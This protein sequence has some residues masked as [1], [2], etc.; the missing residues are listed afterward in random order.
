MKILTIDRKTWARR[1]NRGKKLHYKGEN[2]LKTE[3][4][5]YCCL[6]FYCKDILKIPEDQL[7]NLG[8]PSDLSSR[9]VKLPKDDPYWTYITELNDSRGYK[10]SE[11]EKLIRE[12]FKK[13]LKVK[14][15]FIN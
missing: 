6:G 8:T 12:W 3:E 5:G 10:D 1:T 9:S 14:V 7:L 11:K 13:N 15:R 4:G 2:S